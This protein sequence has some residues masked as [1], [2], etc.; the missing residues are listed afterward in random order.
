MKS[1]AGSPESQCSSAPAR[2]WSCFECSWLVQAHLCILALQAVHGLATELPAHLHRPFQSEL[3][4]KASFSISKDIASCHCRVGA[5]PPGGG[6]AAAAPRGS[7]QASNVAKGAVAQREEPWHWGCHFRRL[8]S[9]SCRRHLPHKAVRHSDSAKGLLAGAGPHKEPFVP[10][11]RLVL[12]HDG[13]GG[14]CLGMPLEE[15]MF[16]VSVKTTIYE[17]TPTTAL[18]DRVPARVSSFKFQPLKGS[19]SSG[20]LRGHWTIQ[21]SLHQLA[22]GGFRMLQLAP[23]QNFLSN[24]NKSPP[25]A[26]S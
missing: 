22:L 10:C 23:Q 9:G 24:H 13:C 12:G 3:R 26:G 8:I 18:S 21:P 4:V 15:R 6:G 7:A 1:S 25:R 17:S 19:K 2:S 5:A 14:S 16:T 11:F 20:K